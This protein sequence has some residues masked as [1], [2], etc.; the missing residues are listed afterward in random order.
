MI[1]DVEPSAV[2][3]LAL[4]DDDG[5]PGSAEELNRQSA[6]G[7]SGKATAESSEQ[8]AQSRMIFSRRADRQDPHAPLEL[9]YA[10]AHLFSDLK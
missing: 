5:D 1:Q 3:E 7:R 6:C 4:A 2:R 9:R 10:R 8:L